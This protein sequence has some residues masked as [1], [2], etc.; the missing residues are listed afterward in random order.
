MSELAQFPVTKDSALTGYPLTAA[1]LTQALAA[2]RLAGF[3]PVVWIFSWPDYLDAANLFYEASPVLIKGVP[4]RIME[5]RQ[6][7]LV[8]LEREPL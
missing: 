7:F 8:A 2:A 4:V 5:V 3:E 6:S 1:R